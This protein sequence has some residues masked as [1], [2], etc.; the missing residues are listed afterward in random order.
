MKIAC[1]YFTIKVIFVIVSRA[2]ESEYWLSANTLH[3]LS[4]GIVATVLTTFVA[5]I[6]WKTDNDDK[7]LQIVYET[8][9][10]ALLWNLF[11]MPMLF[12][13]IGMKLDF[14]MMTWPTVLTGCA[15]IAIGAVFRFFSGIIFTCYSDFNLKEQL[16]LA[17]SLLPKATVQVSPTQ[18]V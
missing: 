5:S 8:K 10:F 4:G 11:F 12:A 13:L 7:P 1:S 9:A 3:Y 16:L 17:T 14:S 18:S 2:H 6:R 15:L